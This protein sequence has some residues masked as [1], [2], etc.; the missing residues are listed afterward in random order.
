MDVLYMIYDS[1]MEDEQ[2]IKLLRLIC[3]LCHSNKVSLP[4]L[5]QRGWLSSTTER[6]T[7]GCRTDICA[8]ITDIFIPLE[9]TLALLV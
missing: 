2:V 1:S 9:G 5:S 8:D 6:D 4:P 7:I 3:S